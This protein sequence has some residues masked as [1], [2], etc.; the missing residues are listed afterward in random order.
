MSESASRPGSLDESI[1]AYE[2]WMRVELGDRLDAKGL[3][4]KHKRMRDHPFLFLRAT[5]WRWAEGAPYLCPEL[6]DA[7]PV[8]SVGDAHA[9]NF[10]LWRDGDARL[11]WGVNDLDEAARLPWCL[12]LVR[13][14]ASVI[15]A[16]PG[17]DPRI[18]ADA[19]LKG[20]AAGLADPRPFVLEREHLWLRDA[21]AADDVHREEFWAELEAGK[22][23]KKID[24]DLRDALLAALPEPGLPAV[25]A[26]REAGAGSL[27]RP[28]FTAYAQHRGG[29]VAA[30]IKGVLPSCWTAY[31][32]PGMPA[33]IAAG[34]FRSP[35]PHFRYTDT[36]VTRRLAPNS[37]KLKLTEISGAMRKRLLAAMGADL[38]AIHAEDEAD[39]TAIRRDLDRRN[40]RWLEAASARVAAWTVEEQAQYAAR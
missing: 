32:E 1:A 33:R 17:H 5:C 31:R 15:L 40:R 16:P 9:G 39:R 35:D 4:R 23:A 36:H 7:P 21:F 19:I 12:D 13:L 30:E 34:R 27:G 20:Y 24:F 8:P 22:P 29:P 14:C 26:R 25:I 3:E 37:R 18:A 6:M 10:G 2:A 11:V 28:R 38:A